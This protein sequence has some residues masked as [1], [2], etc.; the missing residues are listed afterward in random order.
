MGVTLPDQLAGLAMARDADPDLGFPGADAGA[1]Q[2][3][4]SQPRQ[5]FSL[6]QA[7][8]TP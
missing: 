8:W 1:L 3:A 5:V 2:P 4:P 7:Q 6:H